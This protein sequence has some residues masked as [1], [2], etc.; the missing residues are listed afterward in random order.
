M[1]TTFVSTATCFSFTIGITYLATLPPFH[2]IWLGHEC[3]KGAAEEHPKGRRGLAGIDI[4]R[5][6]ETEIAYEFIEIIEWKDR[7]EIKGKATLQLS[8]NDK[9]ETRNKEIESAHRF[10]DTRNNIE[11]FITKSY[12][13]NRARSRIFEKNK[14]KFSGLMYNK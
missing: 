11:I 4:T 5:N 7:R 1:T 8:I 3:G 13:L 12:E 6:S 2:N 14:S 9:I 10:V